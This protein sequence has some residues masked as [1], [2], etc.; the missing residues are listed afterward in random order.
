MQLLL[1]LI[2]IK[3]VIAYILLFNKC[4]GINRIRTLDGNNTFYFSNRQTR[5]FIL[6]VKQSLTF[7]KAHVHSTVS[8]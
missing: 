4:F 7:E 3:F 5:F 2:C 8:S 1:N 6:T